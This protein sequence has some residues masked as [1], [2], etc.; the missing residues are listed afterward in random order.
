MHQGGSMEKILKELEE[1]VFI[2]LD[3]LSGYFMD[4]D[5]ILLKGV[6]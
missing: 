1:F 3:E 2:S 4:L 6:I 5:H